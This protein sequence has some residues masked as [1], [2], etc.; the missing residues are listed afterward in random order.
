MAGSAVYISRDLLILVDKIRDER[1]DETRSHTAR[2]L[3]RE[4]LKNRG[5]LTNK[6][7]ANA[8]SDQTCPHCSKKLPTE[9]GL[10]I[11]I[12]RMHKD[13]RE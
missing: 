2:V 7:V 6:E 11:H 4:A 8:I 9:K 5:L 1:K 12:S 13:R 10:K 3:L